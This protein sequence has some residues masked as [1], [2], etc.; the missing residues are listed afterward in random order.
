MNECCCC[1][2]LLLGTLQQCPHCWLVTLL[3]TECA[4]LRQ[5]ATAW[6]LDD[7]THLQ[8]QQQK[9]AAGAQQGVFTATTCAVIVKHARTS[10]CSGDISAM[11]EVQ[12]YCGMCVS[13]SSSSCECQASC[14]VSALCPVLSACKLH[15]AVPAMHPAILS[16]PHCLSA[17][18]RCPP[19]GLCQWW[20]C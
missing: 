5:V 16:S 18:S 4:A 17:G 9:R 3:L 8:G 7:S 15:T 1:G 2:N 12:A 10:D 19:P 13:C 11:E 14:E 20:Y 6:L